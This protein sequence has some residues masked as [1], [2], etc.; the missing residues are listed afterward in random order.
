MADDSQVSLGRI[1]IVAEVEIC[2]SPRTAREPH[3]RRSDGWRRLTSP[4]QN[5]QHRVSCAVL[6]HVYSLCASSLTFAM[7]CDA[8]GLCTAV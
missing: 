6:L 1:F 8:G 4:T 3:E 2:S 7:D 5:S